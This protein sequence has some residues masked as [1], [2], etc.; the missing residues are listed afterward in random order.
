MHP[1]DW[2]EISRCWHAFGHS[3]HGEFTPF[4][5]FCRRFLDET[6]AFHFFF[7]LFVGE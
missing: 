1:I 7:F 2:L 4:T 5:L 3:G 6:E